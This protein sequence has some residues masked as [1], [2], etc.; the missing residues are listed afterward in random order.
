MKCLHV[1]QRS[2]SL[3]MVSLKWPI[4]LL[5]LHSKSNSSGRASALERLMIGADQNWLHPAAMASRGRQNSELP[6][7]DPK[8][9]FHHSC[10]SA[11]QDSFVKPVSG[12]SQSLSPSFER[13][14]VPRV[15]FNPK[16]WGT[17]EG[18]SYCSVCPRLQ[19][20]SWWRSA[21]FCFWHPVH[22]KLSC[23]QA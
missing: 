9:S 18:Q 6:K 15:M 11:W 22:A 8:C 17:A 4:W 7:L 5:T 16:A 3:F 10:C 20:H 1:L 23:V 13:W 19:T 2:G 12:T 14:G 21:L